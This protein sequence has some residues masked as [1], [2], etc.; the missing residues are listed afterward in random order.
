MSLLKHSLLVTAL[1]LVVL[2]GAALA[3]PPQQQVDNIPSFTAAIRADLTLLVDTA[4]PDGRP[5]DWTDNIDNT[6]PSYVPDLWYDKELLANEVFGEDRRPPEWFGVTVDVADVLACNVRHDLELIADQVF[7]DD[8][9]PAWNG[10]APIYRCSRVL[11]NTYF[12][13]INNYSFITSFNADDFG[14][15]TL[16]ENELRLF[17]LEDRQ[18]ELSPDEL[19]EAILATRGDIERL[20]NEAFG[21]NDRP[22]G[23]AGNTDINSPLLLSD[24]RADLDL[25]ADET[26]GV[27]VRPDGWVGLVNEQSQIDTWRNIRH[28]LEVLADELVPT[29]PSIEG[30]R[31]RGWQNDDPLRVCSIPLQDLVMV[32][33]DLFTDAD[34][35]FSRFDFELGEAYCD[36]VFAAAN[37]FAEDSP[38]SE[39]EQLLATGNLVFEAE[40][41]FAYLDLTAL[42]SLKLRYH[43]R[44]GVPSGI[45]PTYSS[46]VRSR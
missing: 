40:F 9:P 36:T 25:L 1:L 2:A 13:A 24:N 28:D 18:L 14:F 43:A 8:R 46:A 26:L 29:F 6:S 30:D 32:L 35:S 34:A 11:Q 5:D 4:L 17:L 27:N 42:E 39:L 37:N 21:V 15:C 44:K 33:E 7:N 38:V 19:G 31:P 23:W 12:L 16:V 45:E 10:A 20:A 22:V 3:S 41:A